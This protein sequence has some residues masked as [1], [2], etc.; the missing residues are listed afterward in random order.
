SAFNGS[1]G[2]LLYT[3]STDYVLPN[4]NW[5]PVYQP[6]L[7]NTGTG[8]RLY[9]PGAGGTVYYIDNPDSSAHSA[10]VRLAF[11]GVASF[12]SN[13][14]GF[15]STVFIDTPISADSSGNIFFGF[16][17]QGTAPAPLSTSQSGFARIDSAGNGVY[18]LAGTATGDGQISRDSHNSAPALSNDQSTLYVVAKSGTTEY[19]G[20]LLG[21]DSATLATKYKVFLRDPRNGNGGGILDDS[22]ASPMVA[23]DNDVYFGIFSNPDNGSRGFMLRFSSDL[24]V[25][26]TPG[27][28][29]WDFT[30]AVVPASMVTAYTGNSPYLIFSKYNNYA[31][32]AD[33]NGVDRIA[34]LDP[35]STQID[36]HPTANNLME[37]RELMTVIGVTPDSENPGVPNAVREW[38]IN[39]PAVNPATH[40]IFTPS[41][42][43][44]VYRWNLD[45]NSL[46]EMIQIGSG[47]GEPYVPTV[48]GPDG[49]I[50]ALNGGNLYALGNV[51]GVGISVTS[52]SP[53][54]RTTVAGQS[55][56]FTATVTNTGPSQKTPT[57]TVTFQDTAFTGVTPNTTTLAS[58]VVLSGGVATFTTSSLPAGSHFITA[59]Y[60]GGNGFSAGSAMMAQNIHS[61][62][63]TT[64]V[65]AAPNPAAPGQSVTFTATVT[66][67]P[68]GSPPEEV[69]TFSEGSN[70]LAQ[71]PVSSSGVASFSTAALSAGNHTITAAYPSDSL[72]TASSGNVVAA[73]NAAA[74][75]VVISLTPS[76][77]SGTSVTFSAVYSDPNGIADLSQVQLLV[78]SSVT[79]GNAC[80]L[81]Y[82]RQTN[83][84]YL[85]SDAGTALLSPGLT[86]GAGTVSNSQ[87]TLNGAGS[88]VNVSGNNITVNAAITFASS[89][90]GVRNVYLY[91]LGSGGNTGFIQKGTWTPSP[92]SGPPTVVS[93]SPSSGSGSS[94][95][96]TAVYSDPNGIADLSQVQLL[97]NTGVAAANA[98]YLT[99]YPQTNLLYL[100][101]DAGTALLSPALTPGSGTVSNSQCTLNAAGSSAGVSGNNLTLNV[102]LTFSNSFVGAH[103]V[104][105]YASGFSGQ[106]SGFIQK[107]SWTPSAG[108]GPPTV[109]S[110]S[111]NSGSGTSVTFTAVYSDPNGVA[112]L[113]QLQLLVNT[114]VSAANACYLSYYPQTNRLYL[115][116]DAGTSLLSPALTPGSGTVSNSQCTLNGAGSSF[117]V[118]GNNVTL[119]VALSFSSSVVGAQNVYLYATG[120]SGQ[121]SGFVQKGSW[122][123]SAGVGPPS[124]VS[125]TPSNAS[126]SSVTFT[127]VYSDPNGASDLSQVQFL[128]N[129][130]LTGSN[131]CYV[132]Y[133]P[134]T[135]LLYLR[136]DAGSA[137]LS[138]ALVPGGAGTVSNSQC[139]LNG[140]GSSFSISGN[141]L[142]LNVAVT[143]S[144]SFS[145]SH[146]V[147]LYATGF[148][149]QSS[150]FVQKGS[151]A[152]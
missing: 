46:S 116:N 12:N 47:V 85:R 24:S 8:T 44:H 115:R 148:S 41:E 17:V 61:S 38:C 37:M 70:V 80:Y 34:L 21:L 93:L 96:F 66:P 90:N 30:A 122:T 101:N 48:I 35:N 18:V 82:Y 135:N 83:R 146:K 128:V 103:N 126:G 143:F 20:Y 121:N 53:D 13:A 99:Y 150:G 60:S 97:V 95:T 50:Y 130:A 144:G 119:K 1:T 133:Y 145:G 109:V 118:S 19:Y 67:A 123:P 139:T 31:N 56:T 81:S 105:L 57:G 136:S 98:C 28:F 127:A 138:P 32:D 132:S 10:P 27:A 58:N 7:V 71:V 72:L 63:S 110:V 75:P 131:A 40:S 68:A 29:G 151:W 111:P 11:Y 92:T 39:S 140:A 36:P 102:S 100:R 84:L 65:A 23:P 25:Q 74:P 124:V 79:A 86:P 76:S 33:G 22:T 9:Y 149:G 73:V 91:A 52:N 6:V 134:K 64:Q 42:D 16:R 14:S 2:G 3:L 142:T 89:F 55:L 114:G 4:Y 51:P 152:P 88:S 87:C 5:F 62:A 77:G 117:S 45:T 49:T 104:Y 15:T 69:L 147:Y 112:D 106:N 129:T 59:V 26:K 137:L 94:A 125:L 141:N 43:G 113:N 78:N 120:F 54:V 108:A 107:G